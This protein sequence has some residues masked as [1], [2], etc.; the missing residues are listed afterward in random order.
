MDGA[1]S[2]S[3]GV[4][5][6]R[7]WGVRGSVPSPGAGTVRYG[8]N[9]SCV[10]IEA[11]GCDLIVLDAG[12]GIR[13][14][15]AELART[16]RLPL[17]AHLLLSHTH[18]DHI[19]GFPFFAP[20]FMPGNR[21]V[22]HGVRGGDKDLA[23]ALE[24]QMQHRYFPV[25]LGDLGADILFQDLGLGTHMVG[26]A[27]IGVAPT[28]HPGGGVAYRIEVG[29]RAIVY[30]TDT[31]PDGDF[32]DLKLDP[33]VLALAEDADVLIYDSQYTDDGYQSKV[34][35]GH[36]PVSYA[37]RLAAAARVGHLV[38]FHHDPTHD[39]AAIDAMVA[40]A[41]SLAT[42]Y[43][44]A[45]SL[46]IDAAAEG[47]DL[48][49]PVRTDAAVAPAVTTIAGAST[50][51]GTRLAD[52]AIAA[53]GEA[54][55]LLDVPVGERLRLLRKAPIFRLLRDDELQP[56]AEA[57]TVVA[58]EEGETI[59]RQGEPGEHVF[60]IAHGMVDVSVRN[61]DAGLVTAVH[62][63]THGEGEALGELALVDGRPR[64]GTAVAETRTVCLK[65]GRRVFVDAARQHWSVA[66]GLL[67]VLAERLRGA[68]ARLGDLARDQLTGVYSAGAFADL[69]EREAARSGR[70]ARRLG[71]TPPPLTLLH[72]DV[73]GLRGINEAHGVRAGDEVLKAAARI[74]SAAIRVVDAV[75][76]VGGDEFAVLLPDTDAAGAG[77]VVDRVRRLL[78]E[79]PLAPATFTMRLGIAI[80][81]PAQPAPLADLL[82]VAERDARQAA[83]TAR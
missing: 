41:R 53:D 2:A 75:A 47:W 1:D 24:G 9:T 18:W 20:V 50:A 29:G 22:I 32:P 23:E 12:T 78:L 49:L 34:G 28:R 30:A 52:T 65:L 33:N 63:G 55:A 40:R 79:R 14:L 48:A 66:Q 11:P 60:I 77:V 43:A 25:R 13:Q 27:R 81:D 39:D 26:G 74:L 58:F 72:C 57:C 76:R 46:K 68:D 69:Y 3:A 73:T 44:L 15:G 59:L 82:V 61:Y 5:R 19:Q 54:E 51:G 62:V 37:V 16:G 7:F 6:V 8:G 71:G 67:A 42:T 21:L 10:S 45:H 36:S 4:A 56:L 64:S 31:E 80:A 17:T 35:W 38:L 83:L 70:L